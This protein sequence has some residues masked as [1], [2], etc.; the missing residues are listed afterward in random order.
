MNW[1][2]SPY[3][4]DAIVDVDDASNQS[5][6]IHYGGKLIAES[7]EQR[8]IPLLIAAPS[9]FEALDAIDGFWDEAEA[10]DLSTQLSPDAL[11]GGH[12]TDELLT[13]REVVKRAIAAARAAK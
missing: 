2:R 6:N 1:Q 3:T 12:S 8:N 9:M 4:G 10:D 13:I 7:I 11:I 5:C